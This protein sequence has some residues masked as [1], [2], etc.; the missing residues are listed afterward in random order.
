MMRRSILVLAAVTATLA[1]PGLAHAAAGDLDPSFSGDGK[2]LTSIPGTGA[3][4][5]EAIDSKG[6][7]VVAGPAGTTAKV[8]VARYLPSGKLDTSFGNNGLVLFLFSSSGW[9]TGSAVAID[10]TDRVVVV[11]Q[12]RS[13]G[14]RARDFGVARLTAHGKLDPSFSGDGREVTHVGGKISKDAANSVAIDSAGRIVAA[15]SSWIGGQTPDFTLVRY[16]ANGTLDPSFS[17]DGVA[18]TSFGPSGDQANSVAIDS[19]GR[20]VAAGWAFDSGPG[21]RGAV[22]R[23]RPDGSL[24]PTFSG[25][26]KSVLASSGTGNELKLVGVAVDDL[27]RIVTAGEVFVNGATRFAIVRLRSNGSLDTSF[28]GGDGM[29]INFPKATARSVAIDPDGRIVAAGNVQ[30]V[31]AGPDHF[32]IARYTPS[33]EPD[34]SFSGDGTVTTSVGKASQISAAFAVAID[35]LGRI[36]AAGVGSQGNG[37]Q[38]A[39]ARYLSN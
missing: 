19:A 22:A 13:S 28:G 21:Y 38:F 32:A 3:G 34:T 9:S 11:G 31:S 7:I 8:A 25:D 27:N 39:L 15:G 18:R 33:G 17:G 24:D 10:S 20:I 26:G 2:V 35:P 4:H 16:R 5:G 1:V 6:R 14:T 23:Y 29:A 37:G 12:S 36:V 30:P